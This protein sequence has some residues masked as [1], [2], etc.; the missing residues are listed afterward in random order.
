MKRIDL[1]SHEE[2]IQQFFLALPP[3]PEGSVVELNGKAVARITPLNAVAAE[4]C[5]DGTAWSDLKNA[6][7]CELVDREIEGTLLP[8]EVVE[9]ALL[10]QQM[11]TERRR[12]APVALNDLRRLHQEL[13]AKA[14]LAG[15]GNQ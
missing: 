12:L 5:E 6:R 10:Q 8:H 9:L 1:K 15:N 4:K 3:D 7:R 14:E 2:V 11:L 13:L